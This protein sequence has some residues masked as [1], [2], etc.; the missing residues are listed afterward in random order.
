[1]AT[2][3]IA[4]DCATTAATAC[5][6]ARGRPDPSSF[7]TRTLMA[8]FRPRNTMASHPLRF[9]LESMIISLSLITSTIRKKKKKKKKLNAYTPYG[10]GSHGHLRVVEASGEH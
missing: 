5:L 4:S 8:A 3:P 2:S 1:M 6:A 10:D 9:M 7:D